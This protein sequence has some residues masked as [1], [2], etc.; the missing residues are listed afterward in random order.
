[1]VKVLSPVRIAPIYHSKSLYLLYEEEVVSVIF[2]CIPI[3]DKSSTSYAD[4]INI[5]S[6]G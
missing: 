6:R 5:E 3:A 2:V 4:T 1:M